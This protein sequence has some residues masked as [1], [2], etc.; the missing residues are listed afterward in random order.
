MSWDIASRVHPYNGCTR[1]CNLCM[2]ENLTSEKEEPSYLLHTREE[3]ISKCRH[4]NKVIPN[5]SK[6]VKDIHVAIV[7]ASC[8]KSLIKW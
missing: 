5:A 6:S 2:T 3:I 8:S 1:K 7:K 4:L